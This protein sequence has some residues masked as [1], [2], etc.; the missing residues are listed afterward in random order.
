MKSGSLNSLEPSG[1]LQ[2]CNG[3]ALPLPLPLFVSIQ[4]SDVCVKVSFIIVLFSLNFSCRENKVY[5]WFKS[6]RM[7]DLKDC[8]THIFQGAVV[9][10][11][12]LMDH[13]P[14]KCYG[15]LK[16]WELHTQPHIIMSWPEP[17]IWNMFILNLFSVASSYSDTSANEDNS[18]R[19]HIR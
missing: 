14:L 6:S 8:G 19:N 17:S 12:F 16:N 1:P 9:Q 3:T 4:V 2:A 10:E 15:P 11:E 13:L 5:T 18:F 7:D